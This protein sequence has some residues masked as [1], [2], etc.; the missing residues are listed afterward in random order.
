[1][2]IRYKLKKKFPKSYFLNKDSAST[3]NQSKKIVFDSESDLEDEI[4]EK[5][6]KLDLT[7]KTPAKENNVSNGKININK[8]KFS[9]LSS[10]SESESEEI[11][12]SKN[13]LRNKS[14]KANKDE[15]ETI[16]MFESKIN[17]DQKKANKV[18]F[19]VIIARFI[20]NSLL[21]FV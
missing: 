14:L 2:N 16:K 20:I 3:N 17:L 5:K 11:R 13:G 8:K 1:M 15:E 21:N 12:E 7:L 4:V 6:L 18:K 10:G 19:F 9:L